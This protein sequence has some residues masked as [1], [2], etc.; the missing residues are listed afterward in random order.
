M[1]QHSPVSV[2][3]RITV[4]IKLRIAQKIIEALQEQQEMIEA[5]QKENVEM[6]MRLDKLEGFSAN[7]K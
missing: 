1:K 5:L 7:S 4:G 2:G 6:R 3:N